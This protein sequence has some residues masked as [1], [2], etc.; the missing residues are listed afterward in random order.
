MENE[1]FDT[2]LNEYFIKDYEHQ[3]LNNN[4]KYVKWKE[5]MIHKHGKNVKFVHCKK[6][7]IIFVCYKNLLKE[8]PVYLS[9]CPICKN[10]VCYFCSR[11]TRYGECCVQRNI[12]YIFLHNGFKF[13]KKVEEDNNHDKSDYK[14]KIKLFIIPFIN[15]L[16]FIHEIQL[17]LFYGLYPKEENFDSYD[18]YLRRHKYIFEIVFG[19][20]IAFEILLCIPYFLF[21]INFIISLLIFSIPFKN[22]PLKYFIGVAYG[23]SL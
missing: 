6:D 3:D 10:P 11:F 14:K 8:D 9:N 23:N 19:I 4:P 7:N 12:A 2:N 22:Y 16:I 18:S 1:R 17:S 13:I 5:E 21:S 15:L 20:N